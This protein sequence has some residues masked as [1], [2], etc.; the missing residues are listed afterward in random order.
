MGAIEL[1]GDAVAS[2]RPRPLC[3]ERVGA[4][5][6]RQLVLSVQFEAADGRRWHAIGG[7]DTL[8]EALAFAAESCPGGTDWRAVRWNDLYGE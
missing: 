2:R 6:G 1:Q 7:G 3:E 5:G 8:E 4:A